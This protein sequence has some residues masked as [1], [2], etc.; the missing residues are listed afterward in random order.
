MALPALAEPSAPAGGQP[1]APPMAVSPVQL[2]G[3][4]AIPAVVPATGSGAVIPVPVRSPGPAKGSIAALDPPTRDL[5][6]RI[7]G[8]FNA[9]TVASGEFVQ[10]APDG[11]RTQG[12]FYLQKP[13]KV[14]F[15]YAP[16]SP[17]EF[18]SDG[19]SIAVRDRKLATQEITPLSQTPLR[20]LLA[21]KIDL[22][23]DAPVIAVQK[24]DLFVSVVLEERHPVAGTHRLMLM[25]GAQDYQLKQWT[26]TDPQGFDTTVAIY[27]VDTTKRPSADL[28]RINYERVLQ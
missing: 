1:P 4:E 12:H 22:L 15:D 25:F 11:S 16:P 8:V 18:I 14:R 21:E 10:V 23:R 19:G 5:V 13:G 20:F 26:V 7:N 3:A 6:Q 9:L 2:P 27:N 24:D 28:F 17:I